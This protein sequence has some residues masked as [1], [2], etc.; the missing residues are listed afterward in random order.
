MT[1]LETITRGV[2][3]WGRG[4][5]VKAFFL[6]YYLAILHSVVLTH[7]LVFLFPF[8]LT[9]NLFLF[10]F[11]FLRTCLYVLGLISKTKQGCELLKLHGW[12]AVRHNRRQLWPVVPDEVEQHQN[13]Q[14]QQQQQQ[15]LIHLSSA[16]STLSLNSES[17]SSRHNSESDSTQ[18][19]EC[20]SH[21]LI[22]DL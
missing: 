7:T 6:P 16:P 10:F 14:Q 3:L 15:P 2:F 17:T 22:H 9:H 4:D 12:D 21:P 8:C 18:P 5:F 13:L 20:C 11:F 19:S 1:F